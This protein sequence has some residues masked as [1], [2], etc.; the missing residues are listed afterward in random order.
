MRNFNVIDSES[1]CDF[2]RDVKKRY[3]KLSQEDQ[4]ELV[5]KM[6]KGDKAAKEK[7]IC[8]NIG[9]IEMIARK[10]NV[11][12]VFLEDKF[13]KGLE[14]FIEKIEKFD[15][16]RCPFLSSYI[17]RYVQQ[18]I[19]DEFL[20]MPVKLFKFSTSMIKARESFANENDRSP[21]NSELADFLGVKEKYLC[22]KQREIAN[23]NI[24]SLDVPVGDVPECPTLADL[25]EDEVH[26]GPEAAWFNKELKWSVKAALSELSE[27]ERQILTLCCD[28]NN[29]FGK[30]CTYR[31][32][33]S[34]LG[35]SHQTV[36]NKLNAAKKHLSRILV[37]YGEY[38]Q[39]A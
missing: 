38:Y 18:A 6:K 5:K 33:G 9:L 2:L 30:K 12:G 20:Q 13:F 37:D 7:L 23:Y 35:L 34:L 3:P 10:T 22:K 28:E 8:S 39:A 32:A 11:P 14:C 24:L 25:I 26:P 17:W 1:F 29:Q 27:E 4:L 15:P 16:E 21:K 19:F 31:E 36:A